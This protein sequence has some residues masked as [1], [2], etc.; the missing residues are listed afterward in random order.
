[1]DLFGFVFRGRLLRFR[2]FL[3]RFVSLISFP[4]PFRP[5]WPLLRRAAATGGA[6]WVYRVSRQFF[7]R[8]L[9]DLSFRR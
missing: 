4:G 1:M 8:F 5:R 2:F 7:Q 3:S 9:P 6:Y